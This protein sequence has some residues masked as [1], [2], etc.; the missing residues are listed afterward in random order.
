MITR[1]IL[2]DDDTLALTSADR[3]DA[4]PTIAPVLEFSTT[5]AGLGE[6]EAAEAE[7]VRAMIEE[8]GFTRTVLMQNF[9]ARLDSVLLP[10]TG[11]AAAWHADSLFN[12]DAFDFTLFRCVQGVALA[13]ES[14]KGGVAPAHVRSA[15]NAVLGDASPVPCT[16]P[17]QRDNWVCSLGDFGWVGLYSQSSP[18]H[19]P[20]AAVAVVGLDPASWAALRAIMRSEWHLRL[21]MREVYPKLAFWRDLARQNGRRALAT[22]VRCTGRALHEPERMS[23]SSTPYRARADAFVGAEALAWFGNN[24]GFKVPS[25]F[26]FPARA[27]RDCADR[28]PGA[29]GSGVQVPGDR[30]ETAAWA[31]TP[32]FCVCMDDVAPLGENE[33]VRLAGCGSIVARESDAPTPVAIVR[34]P[35]DDMLVYAESAPDA[36]RIARSLGAYA[37]QATQRDSAVASGA[38]DEESDEDGVRATWEDPDI[39][40]PRTLAAAFTFR[41][42]VP[43]PPNDARRFAPMFVRVSCRDQRGRATE[44]GADRASRAQGLEADDWTPIAR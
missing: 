40:R 19:P 29:P 25:W 13:N 41:A 30:A 23:Y 12:A 43:P 17:E 6:I 39:A 36:S 34:G 42:D 28:M 2:E 10:P 15:L 32:D 4:R 44:V 26:V 24:A 7:R 38:A 14:R 1:L 21:T 20:L 9:D 11:Y 8:C 37:A 31:V 35:A 22:F 5:E 16:A 18:R 3:W 27:P 33:Y